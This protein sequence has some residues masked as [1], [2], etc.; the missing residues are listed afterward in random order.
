MAV[1]KWERMEPVVNSTAFRS[2]P[3]RNLGSSVLKSAGWDGCTSRDRWTP[4]TMSSA[5]VGARLLAA[6]GGFYPFEP[7]N[8]QIRP[9]P[10]IFSSNQRGPLSRCSVFKSTLT[11][12]RVFHP[13]VHPARTGGV[14]TSR[15]HLHRDPAIRCPL[16]LKDILNLSLQR[17]RVAS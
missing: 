13:F 8:L 17:C 12:I 15:P 4:S 5:F 1:V 10:S 7:G 11:H 9:W 2:R 6:V 16:K 3:W 14:Y